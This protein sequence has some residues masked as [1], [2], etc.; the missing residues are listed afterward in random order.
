[1]EIKMTDNLTPEQK[2]DQ[3]LEDDK[4]DKPKAA[5]KSLMEKTIRDQENRNK[6]IDQAIDALRGSEAG[7][8]RPTQGETRRELQDNLGKDQSQPEPSQS[9]CFIGTLQDSPEVT[10]DGKQKLIEKPK[11]LLDYNLDEVE[12]MLDRGE[13]DPEQMNAFV[14]IKDMEENGF[15]NM[16]VDSAE[17]L[18][19]NGQITIDQFEDYLDFQE[20]PVWFRVK[21]MAKGVLHGGWSALDSAYQILKMSPQVNP[22]GMFTGEAIPDFMKPEDFQ[23]M[24]NPVYP[25]ELPLRPEDPKTGYGQ[26][27]STTTEFL[28]PFLGASKALKAIKFVPKVLE[29]AAPYLAKSPKLA[30]FLQFT[31]EGTIAG[32]F[33]DGTVD[34]YGGRLTDLFEEAD[35][36]P[37]F[38]EFMTTDPNNPEAVERFKN[39]V[40]GMFVGP[41]VDSVLWAAKVVRRSIIGKHGGNMDAVRKDLLKNEKLRELIRPYDDLKVKQQGTEVYEREI[42]QNGELKFKEDLTKVAEDAQHFSAVDTLERAGQQAAESTRHI[43]RKETLAQADTLTKEVNATAKLI[44]ASEKDLNRIWADKMQR[45]GKT[46]QG[47]VAEVVAQRKYLS[48]Y[49]KDT[50]KKIDTIL[51]DPTAATPEQVIRAVEHIKVVQEMSYYLEGISSESGR[52][53][54]SYNLKFM[55]N[56]FDF[57]NLPKAGDGGV[58]VLDDIW[59]AKQADLMDALRT[60]HSGIDL[61]QRIRRAK[62]LGSHKFLRGVLEYTQASLL[63]NPGT[64]A[65]NIVGNSGAYLQDTLER[66]IAG[67]VQ[68]IRH[69]D[70]SHMKPVLQRFRGLGYG[71]LE[72]FRWKKGMQGLTELRTKGSNAD[73]G[74]V[75]KALWTAESQINTSGKVSP[76]SIL[77]HYAEVLGNK[78][79][80]VFGYNLPK[81]FLKTTATLLRLPF[82]GLAAMDEFF[83]N[84]AYYSDIYESAHRFAK[85]QDDVAE[86]LVKNPISEMHLQAEQLSKELTFQDDLLKGMRVD[87]H[88][89]QSLG[90]LG[91]IIA[92]PFWKVAL[93]I[94]SFGAKRSPLGAFGLSKSWKH[95]FIINEKFAES[96]RRILAGTADHTHYQKMAQITT[97][98]A[99]GWLGWQMYAD[100]R[101][102]GSIPK[103]DRHAAQNAG[104][105]PYSLRFRKKWIQM[106]R[107][108]PQAI[109]FFVGADLAKLYEMYESYDSSNPLAGEELDAIKDMAFMAFAENIT[110]KTWMTSVSQA[111]GMMTDADRFPW[112]KFWGKQLEKLH[113]ATTG[114][115]WF[116]RNFMDKTYREVY[117]LMDGWKRKW[118]SSELYPKRH[119]VYGTSLVREPRFMATLQTST[120]SD[121]PVMQEMLRLRMEVKPPRRTITKTVRGVS[122]TVELTPDQYDK[123]NQY[124]AETPIKDI[125]TK[126]VT[127]EAYRNAKVPDEFRQKKI[128]YYITAARKYAYA[129]MKHEDPTIHQQLHSVF[130][131]KLREGIGEAP[132]SDIQKRQ[133]ERLLGLLPGEGDL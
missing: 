129:K 46:M 16:D 108:D 98:T 131:Q 90:L 80:S 117:E 38:M 91:R 68:S 116:Q 115:D 56:R 19:E 48:Q 125:L 76:Q 5:P 102:V 78:M 126:L 89:I 113:P 26:F 43:P 50:W 30:S 36:L 71:I 47:M 119:S 3:M 60:F 18:L 82:H 114:F 44:G 101:V 14:S 92:V 107:L 57:G 130:M 122:T 88:T 109:V 95:L 62:I 49:T 21:D 118:Y 34:P 24:M 63:Y 65:I 106:N 105:T 110:N 32:G 83:K 79:P 73:I 121:D 4:K 104:I 22:M 96:I 87:N 52:L 97:G 37:E 53:L 77:K 17:W 28:I 93:N 67:G 111:L 61:K 123:L 132:E 54:S 9:S 55:H 11:T 72:S 99:L 23:P 66:L 69:L 112:S 81:A 29:K 51:K 59:N 15:Y 45:T 74:N 10:E 35:M 85:G 127:S 120:V 39:V 12:G 6:S 64:Q 100:N 7:D 94:L 20:S 27:A 86:A 41:V 1:V 33:A 40:E 13:I 84:I 31:L 124:I 8:D 70:L 58:D 25:E 133:Y 128:Q 103:E 42:I 2:L 75:Y